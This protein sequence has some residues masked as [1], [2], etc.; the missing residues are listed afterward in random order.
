MT[1]TA[2]APTSALHLIM[3]D[4]ETETV[5]NH[6]RECLDAEC[7]VDEV[8]DLVNVLKSTEAELQDRLEQVMNMISTLQHLN[9]KKERKTDEV[10]A[11]VSDMLRVFNT[12]VSLTKKHLKT[13]THT[14]TQT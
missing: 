3:S 4:E 14:H 8:E 7:P 11:F 10:R 9:E 5:L 6:A 1:Q 2:S 12:D 13:H